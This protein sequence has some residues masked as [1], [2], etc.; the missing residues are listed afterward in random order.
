M[1]FFPIKIV[2]Y[3]VC[4]P[5][6]CERVTCTSLLQIKLGKVV[7]LCANVKTTADKL[8][9]EKQNELFSRQLFQ[10]FNQQFLCWNWNYDNRKQHALEKLHTRV[11]SKS[12]TV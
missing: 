5:F 9:D 1:S 7:L 8:L 3:F 12:R 6:S 2:A 11:V 10:L 4:P